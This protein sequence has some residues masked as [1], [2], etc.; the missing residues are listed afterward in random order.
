MS[1]F[2]VSVTTRDGEPQKH[3]FETNRRVRTTERELRTVRRQTRLGNAGEHLAHPLSVRP[4]DVPARGRAIRPRVEKDVAD[5]RALDGRSG[6][7]KAM[8]PATAR[9]GHGAWSVSASP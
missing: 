9:P 1:R 2:K 6:W 3:N 5:W 8:N 7:V 4:D